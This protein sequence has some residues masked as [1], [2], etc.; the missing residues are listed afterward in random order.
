[1]GLA[2]RKQLRKNSLGSEMALREFQRGKET[3]ISKNGLG[4]E[5]VKGIL[6]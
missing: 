4:S 6:S 5:R 2:N 1:M 3:A